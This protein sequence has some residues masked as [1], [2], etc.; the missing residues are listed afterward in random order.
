VPM[1]EVFI[2]I[3][4]LKQYVSKNSILGII[5]GMIGIAVTSYNGNSKLDIDLE[6]VMA[7]MAILVATTSYAATSLYINAKCKNIEPMILATG[8][9]IAAALV[10]SPSL[11]FTD[12]STIN[13]KVINSLLGLGFLCT[14][15]AYAFYFKLLAEEGAR[16]AVS[17]VLLIPV[18][19]TIFGTIF[20]NEI[21]TFNKIIG[22]V[23]ILASIKFILNLSHQ[24]LFKI[25]TP[26]AI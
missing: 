10:L 3:F 4:F 12:F 5:L 17:I 16:T 11:L 23:A 8:S 19:G 22:C 13:S 15:I 9:V 25:K 6:R 18:F 7:I 24:N 20:L 21:L 14:G 1:F 26:P 2:S